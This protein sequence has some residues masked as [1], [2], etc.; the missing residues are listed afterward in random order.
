[1]LSFATISFAANLL[2]LVTIKAAQLEVVGVL[3]E[4]AFSNCN[5][6]TAFQ[7]LSAHSLAVCA[8][9]CTKSSTYNAFAWR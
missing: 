8:A 2:N 6:T 3:Y 1:M 5:L 9:I 7:H 4:S